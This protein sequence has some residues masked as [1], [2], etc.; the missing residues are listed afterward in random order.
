[1]VT[2]EI[3][4]NENTIKDRIQFCLFGTT[5]QRKISL[6]LIEKLLLEYEFDISKAAY[7][8]KNK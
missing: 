6:D 7:L 3:M 4:K 5:A 1:M 8:H 2:N